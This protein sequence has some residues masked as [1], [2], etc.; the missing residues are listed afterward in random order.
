MHPP[1]IKREI[2]EPS[3]L[4]LYLIQAFFSYIRTFRESKYDL[5]IDSKESWEILTFSRSHYE[6]VEERKGD[7]Y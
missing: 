2:D 5:L 1:Q 4:S 7:S 3:E 6:C